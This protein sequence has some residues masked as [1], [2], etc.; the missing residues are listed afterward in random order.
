MKRSTKIALITSTVIFVG[1]VTAVAV[2]SARSYSQARARDAAIAARVA[3]NP[4]TPASLYNNVNA[5]RQLAGV[6]ALTLNANLNTSAQAKCDDMVAGNYY[7]H[8]NPTT[9]KQGYEY[10]IENAKSYK[11][12][13]ENLDNTTAPSSVDVITDWL[14]S[15]AHKAAM[16]DPKYTD[17]GFAVC[18]LPRDASDIVT[19]VEHF[20]NFYPAPQAVVNQQAAPQN[21]RTTCY[22]MPQYISRLQGTEFV[23]DYTGS[24]TTCY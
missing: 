10:I 1:L 2:V 22:S 12:A 18:H 23:K 5:Q 21:K 11:D 6:P 15:P 13:S 16:L 4:L 9:N 20:A 3:A 14:N 19:V 7:A 24:T 17:T 8:L